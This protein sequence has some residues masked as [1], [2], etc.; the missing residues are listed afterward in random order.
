MITLLMWKLKLENKDS[1]VVSCFSTKESVSH[2]KP[3]HTRSW[4]FKFMCQLVG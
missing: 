3:L 2:I 1:L 4:Q